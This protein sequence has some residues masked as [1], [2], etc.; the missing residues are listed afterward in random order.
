MHLKG[1][2]S[3]DKQAISRPVLRFFFFGNKR[4]ISWPSPKKVENE[5]VKVSYNKFTIHK[6]R[7][8]DS[9]EIEDEIMLF[10]LKRYLNFF[11]SKFLILSE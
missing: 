1:V 9:H 10:F 2:V 7:L 4:G 8:S 5:K 6:R 11:I 3:L